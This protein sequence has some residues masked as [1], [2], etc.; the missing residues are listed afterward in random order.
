MLQRIA[1]YQVTCGK[2]KPNNKYDCTHSPRR[3]CA[4]YYLDSLVLII[5][6]E[7]NLFGISLKSLIM[8]HPIIIQFSPTN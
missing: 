3:E 7:R 2:Q 6:L 4:A 8:S 5:C 1:S